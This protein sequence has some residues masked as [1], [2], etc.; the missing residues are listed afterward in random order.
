MIVPLRI[1]FYLSGDIAGQ[2]Q[3]GFSLAAW[4]MIIM[5]VCDGPVLDAAE[6]GRTMAVVDPTGL[7]AIVDADAPGDVAPASGVRPARG[8][9]A[10]D[11]SWWWSPA[12]LLPPPARGAGAVRVPEGPDGAPRL[13]DAVRPLDDQSASP[14]AFDEAG[15]R[16]TLWLSLQA[17]VRHRGADDGA[18]AAD[19]AVGAPADP[20][21]AHV[22]RVPHRACRT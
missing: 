18:G 8:S 21:G 15:F 12:G 17:R 19:R 6:A 9:V 7:S 3:L 20:E 2:D 11:R 16:A 14:K 5:A 1:Q 22:H 10:R 13:V 4:M